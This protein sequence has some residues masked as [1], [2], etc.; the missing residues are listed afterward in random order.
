MAYFILLVVA[1]ITALM[2][3]RLRLRV[4]FSG[5]QRL[6]FVGLGRSGPELDFARGVGHVKLFGLKIKSF[7]LKKKPKETAPAKAV[8]AQ[9]IEK[10]KPGKAKTR[11]QRSLWEMILATPQIVRAFW[12]YFVGLVTSVIVEECEGEIR[13]GFSEPHLTGQAFGYYQALVGIIPA[14]GRL[15]FV[16]DWAGASFAGSMRLS[17][18]IPMHAVAYRTFILIVQLPI[19][20]LIRFAR[21]KKNGDSHDQ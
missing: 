8:P 10:E 1:L 18:A 11:R 4:R 2:L 20:R 17:V 16:P 9:P 21:G 14:V 13:A 15:Q 19:R 5:E 12:K 3:L 6:L 7:P